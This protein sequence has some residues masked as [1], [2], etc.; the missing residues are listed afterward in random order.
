[1]KKYPKVFIIVLNYNG[2]DFLKRNISSLFRLNYLDFSVVLVDN[3]S[4]DNS[5][6]SVRRSFSKITI[7]KN[8]ENLGFSAG[9][10]IGIEY[11][12][13]HGADYVWLL[14][15]DTEVLE[16]SLAELISLM[17]K[18]KN[19]GI[20]SPVI[21][22]K[23]GSRIWFAGGKINWLR[24]KTSHRNKKIKADCLN[25]GYISGCAMLVSAEVFK[26]IGLL[27]EDYF[28]YWEDADLSVRA[29]E[30]G[31]RLAVS[32]K[33]RIRHFERSEEKK[34]KKVYWMVIS[35]LIFF[36]KN[37]PFFLRPW[38]F[39]YIGLRKI[40]N[41]LKLMFNQDNIA[42]AVRKAYQDFKYVK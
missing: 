24:M 18:N 13:E 29:R 21:T 4:S 20:A 26:K 23:D 25:S 15:N 10:N 41:K 19:V 30:A 36:K 5:L 7:I 3:N 28:L 6:E 42:K 27:D 39:F 14:N 11:A 17:E 22:E 8:S 38:I 34:D 37:T 40:K 2:G 9:N 33:S 31:Y 32:A 16:N 12:L 35:G 1:M